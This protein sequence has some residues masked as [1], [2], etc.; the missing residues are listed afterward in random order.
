MQK[1]VCTCVQIWGEENRSGQEL[2]LGIREGE[3]RGALRGIGGGQQRCSGWGHLLLQQV[4]RSK[5]G[6]LLQQQGDILQGGVVLLRNKTK[7]T[8]TQNKGNGKTFL[9][10]FTMCPQILLRHQER[11]GLCWCMFYPYADC[12]Y[13]IIGFWLVNARLRNWSATRQIHRF[14]GF[15]WIYRPATFF[16]KYEINAK[17][18]FGQYR[19]VLGRLEIKIISEGL[20]KN[21]MDVTV[22]YINRWM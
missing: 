18:L 19:T 1:K 11:F 7:M 8:R 14:S 15:V 10:M 12:L 16:L 20:V 9:K 22:Q 13:R 5:W 4:R 17:L 2:F 3:E 6:H 21:K